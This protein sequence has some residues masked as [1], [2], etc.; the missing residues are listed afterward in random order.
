VHR[1]PRRAAGL[2]GGRIRGCQSIDLTVFSGRSA[3]IAA[4]ERKR[5][6]VKIAPVGVQILKVDEQ[7]FVMDEVRPG[8]PS[9]DM[10]FDQAIARHPEGGDVLDARPRVVAKVARRRHADESIL[11]A[12][13]AQ[14][15]RDPPMPRDPGKAEPD[16]RQM[17]DPR[18]SPQYQWYSRTLAA[19]PWLR[20]PPGYVVS[21][22]R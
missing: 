17:H 11:A 13:G 15:L 8:V 10:Q 18:R 7:A 14:A 19:V 2:E 16:M 12:E 21:D 3:P 6:A 5:H 9:D 22:F 1:D 4:F 20:P